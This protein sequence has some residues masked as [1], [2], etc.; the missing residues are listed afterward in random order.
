MPK[1]EKIEYEKRVRFVQEWILEDWPSCDI[2]V[3]IIQKWGLEERQAKRYIAEA[4][5]RWNAAD[6]QII[7][8]KRKLKVASLKKLKR[9]LKATYAG[10]PAGIRAVMSVEKEI[11]QLE[12]LRMPTKIDLIHPLQPATNLTDSQFQQL[13]TTAR[14]SKTNS[15]Q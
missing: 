14:E 1:I 5:K 11:I 4:R 10:T 2:I 9:T 3:Q 15:G 8:Q 13:L 7:D 6:D 12:G